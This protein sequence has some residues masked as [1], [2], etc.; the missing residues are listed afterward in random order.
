MNCPISEHIVKHV[1]L[2]YAKRY[3]ICVKTMLVK[4]YAD[5]ISI[6]DLENILDKNV[7]GNKF[8]NCEKFKTELEK[9][10]HP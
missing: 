4:Q 3:M 8:L 10:G 7:K 5:L 9:I 1:L 6:E 2:P